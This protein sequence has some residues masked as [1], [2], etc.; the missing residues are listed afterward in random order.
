MLRRFSLFSFCPHIRVGLNYGTG[1]VRVDELRRT[2][3]I[4]PPDDPVRVGRKEA[5]DRDRPKFGVRFRPGGSSVGRSEI[6]RKQRGGGG[7]RRAKKAPTTT[8]TQHHHPLT[9]RPLVGLGGEEGDRGSEES[10]LIFSSRT[11]ATNHR[12]KTT[13]HRT[14]TWD[15]RNSDRPL[16]SS[17][18]TG[19]VEGRMLSQ[20]TR[21]SWAPTPLYF[22]LFSMAGGRLTS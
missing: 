12:T 2:I 4:V 5:D 9:T 17:T 1:P 20:P 15:D 19:P 7:G 3:A 6:G 14:K 21:G 22:L 11:I 8:T 18:R 16:F 13:T 10:I